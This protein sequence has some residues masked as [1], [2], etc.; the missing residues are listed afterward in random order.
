MT[1]A[2]ALGAFGLFACGGIVSI[3]G[4]GAQPITTPEADGGT[5]PSLDASKDS[6][7]TAVDGGSPLDAGDGVVLCPWGMPDGGALQDADHRTYRRDCTST[8][9]CSVVTHMMDCCGSLIALGA[10]ADEKPRF[11]AKGGVCGNEGAV[12]DCAARNTLAE[13]G[14]ESPYGDL[15][16]VVVACTDNTCKTHATTFA[17]GDKHCDSSTQ[18]CNVSGGGTTIDTY[19][20]MAIPA[21]CATNATCTCID[22]GAP[23]AGFG[24]TCSEHGG[25]VTVR[26]EGI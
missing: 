15:Q 26:F 7:P 24:N 23:D 14:E 22:P 4:D 18:Y 11:V 20:C 1:Y 10:R 6:G 21:N 12:C 25:H 3:G 13:D 17:C 16:D 19:G 8:S 5:A 2:L 9:D